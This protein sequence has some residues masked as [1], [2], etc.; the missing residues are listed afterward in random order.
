[1]YD[2]FCLDAISLLE[3]W[4]PAW[5]S[6]NTSRIHQGLFPVLERIILFLSSLGLLFFLF[7][8]GLSSAFYFSIS[9]YF[10][11]SI[12]LPRVNFVKCAM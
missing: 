2:K 6:V 4:T 8:Q 9:K 12:E 1:M 10:S 5:S 7:Y 3:I 11:I